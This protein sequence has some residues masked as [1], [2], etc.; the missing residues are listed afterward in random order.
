MNKKKATLLMKFSVN[1]YQNVEMEF[2]QTLKNVMMVISK[3]MM[4]AVHHANL[5]MD[6][7]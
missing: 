2:N 6:S 5:K 7:Y 1:V 3:T 4:D